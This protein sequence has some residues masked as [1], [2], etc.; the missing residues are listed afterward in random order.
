LARVF[1]MAWGCNNKGKRI[2]P[3]T[4]RTLV[5]NISALVQIMAVAAFA[6]GKEGVALWSYSANSWITALAPIQD[7]SDP[8]NGGEDLLAGSADDT[9]YCLEGRGMQRGGELWRV[10][11]RSSVTAVAST[12]DLDGD[13]RAD[14]VAGDQANIIQCVSGGSGAVLWKN[15]LYGAPLDIAV[16]PD[17]NG[18]NVADVVVASEDDTVYCFS[19]AVAGMTKSVQLGIIV[20]KFGTAGTVKKPLSAMAKSMQGPPPSKKRPQGANSVTVVQD[21]GARKTFGIVVGAS[22]DTVFCLAAQAASTPPLALW[23]VSTP[24]DVWDVQRCDDVDGDQ[25]DDV[26]VACGADI[27][28]LLSGKT[29][30]VLWSLPVTYG[31]QVVIAVADLNNDGLNDGVVGDGAGSVYCVSGAT[32]GT[33]VAPLWKYAIGDTST[34]LTLSTVGDV[35]SDGKADCAAG[36]SNDMVYLL[37]GSNGAVIWSA[38]TQG[39]VYASTA[40]ADVNG[41]NRTD[42]AVGSGSSLATVY[43]GNGL[44]VGLRD[45]RHAFTAAP[46]GLLQVQRRNDGSCYV[47]YESATPLTIAKFEIWDMHGIL[48]TRFFNTAHGY[49]IQ[50]CAWDG[51]GHNGARLSTGQYILTLKE[52]GTAQGRVL[53]GIF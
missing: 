25:V 11:C 17:L 31:A 23:K 6:A 27:A 5:A 12:P 20:W 3:M 43:S 19:G 7:L 51:R 1:G 41:D 49:G 52:N 21:A 48:M 47:I 16:I 53:F 18:D 2:I 9:L 15:I 26:I 14:A 35:N 8:G 46:A 37:S 45:A 40:I 13:G 29:G 22:S 50:S 4:R 34:I 42:L 44:A 28:Y 10:A 24:G 32:R 33:N 36:S 39:T 30:A 38:N